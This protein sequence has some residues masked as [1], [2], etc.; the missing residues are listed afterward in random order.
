MY[1]FAFMAHWVGVGGEEIEKLNLT[2]N[3]LLK[4]F[5]DIKNWLILQLI[6]K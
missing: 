6:L 1:G 4:N 5:G 2:D 3:I